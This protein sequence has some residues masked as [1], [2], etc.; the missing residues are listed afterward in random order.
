MNLRNVFVILVLACLSC[1]IAQAHCEVPC[2][3]YDDHLRIHL[4]E[5]HITTIE[6][7]QQEINTSNWKKKQD[8]HQ[9][10][11][12]INTKEQHATMIQE[13]VSQYFLTQRIKP[14][15]KGYVDLLKTAHELLVDAS[16]AKQSAQEQT[17]Q[18]LRKALGRFEKLY[19]DA[20]AEK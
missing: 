6:K 17:A 14:T 18:E 3:I 20:T 4:I 15:M 12:W 13:I 8:Q 5:E 1:G 2:G 7:A 19:S 16:K 11:R 9:L 10:V